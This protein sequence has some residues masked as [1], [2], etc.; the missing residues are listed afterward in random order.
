MFGLQDPVATKTSILG[1][2]NPLKL[3]SVERAADLKQ[4]L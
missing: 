3:I 4:D 2:S 1:V